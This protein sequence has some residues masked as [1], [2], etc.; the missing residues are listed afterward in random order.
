MLIFFQRGRHAVALR[1]IACGEFI[2]VENSQFNSTNFESRNFICSNC[3]NHT[4]DMIPGPLNP[5][6]SIVIYQS[7][8]ENE[9]ILVCI[10]LFHLYIGFILLK[11][12]LEC[13]NEFISPKRISNVGHINSIKSHQV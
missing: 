6:V 9:I 5:T 10:L 2:F 11:K 7:R 13:C 12:L 3:M 4:I 8:H 1:K